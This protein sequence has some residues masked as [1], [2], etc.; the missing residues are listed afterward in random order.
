MFIIVGVEYKYETFDLN[1][2]LYLDPPD[3]TPDATGGTDTPIEVHPCTNHNGHHEQ[4]KINSNLQT[5]SMPPPNT[6]ASASSTSLA[7]RTMQEIR[8]AQRLARK[9]QSSPYHW[10][11]CLV[12]TAYSLWFLGLPGFV[13]AHGRPHMTLRTGLALLQRM[14]RLRLHPA[15]EIC[16]RVMMQLCGAYNQPMLAV[17]VLFEMRNIDL[18]PNAVTYGYYNKAVLESEWPSGEE[19]LRVNPAQAR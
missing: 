9:H 14:K 3:D 19:A 2:S 6:P 4:H 5:P 15:D 16:Y 13:A 7:R 17:K 12:N 18:H 10:A 11:K 8:S 1:P